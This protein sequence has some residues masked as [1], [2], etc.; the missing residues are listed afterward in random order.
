[1][2]YPSVCSEVPTCGCSIYWR[3]A[4]MELNN[5]TLVRFPSRRSAAVWVMPEGQS[6]IVVAGSH[7]WEHGSRDEADRDA[8]WMGRNLGL[9]VR[10]TS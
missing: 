3:S 5:S 10:V 7:G 4:A 9:P 6:W 2:D 1:M 8:A